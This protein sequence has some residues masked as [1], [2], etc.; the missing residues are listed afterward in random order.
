M[1][2]HSSQRHSKEGYLKYVYFNYTCA[3]LY[4]CKS[5]EDWQSGVCIQGYASSCYEVHIVYCG[6]VPQEATEIDKG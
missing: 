3:C 4:V 2:R 1:K 5:K 6:A